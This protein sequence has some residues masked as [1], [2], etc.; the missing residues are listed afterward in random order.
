MPIGYGELKPIDSNTSEAGRSRNRRV[1]FLIYTTQTAP[2]VPEGSAIKSVE[3]ANEKT[4]KII[5]N[6]KVKFTDT[7]MSD[8]DRLVIDFP[9]IFLLPT[10][11][12]FELRQGPFIRARIGYHPEDRFSRVVIDLVYPV[13]YTIE[14]EDNIIYIKLL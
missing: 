2:P 12:S 11:V 5:C 4:V 14:T 9:G 10:Q 3:V 13:N 7:I 8:P 1:D 6:G